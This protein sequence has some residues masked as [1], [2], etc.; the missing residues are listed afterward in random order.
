MYKRTINFTNFNGEPDK[1]TLYFN[2][3][4]TELIELEVGLGDGLMTHLQKI[5]KS[6]DNKEILEAFKMIV[7]SAYGKKSEDGRRFIKNDEIWLEFTESPLYDEWFVIL[8]TEPKA[9]A[10]FINGIMPENMDEMAE[11]MKANSEEMLRM[12]KELDEKLSQADPSVNNPL[13]NPNP[14]LPAMVSDQ[15]RLPPPYNPIS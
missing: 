13:V 1:E 6:E 10:E 4:R 3:T 15:T 9:G 8:L 11:T 7:K 2:L 12:K 5:M 14:G